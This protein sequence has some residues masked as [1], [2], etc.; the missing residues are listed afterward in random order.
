M[1]LTKILEQ[2]LPEIGDA[3]K[4]PYAYRLFSDYG[5]GDREYG[6]V[7]D[8]GT[9]YEVQI[10]DSIHN[11]PGKPKVTNLQ[12]G[13]LDEDGELDFDMQTGDNDVYKV[14]STIV[15]IV[16]EDI[17][18]YPTDIIQYSPSKR[19]GD[20]DSNSNVRDKL[21]SRYIKAQFPNAKIVQTNTRGDIKVILNP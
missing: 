20:K 2:I 7:T 14:M 9:Q 17:K 21:Y 15:K 18:K 5:D 4:E 10:I 6:F 3:T 19:E 1:K 12:F 16:K 13:A 11:K 8:S